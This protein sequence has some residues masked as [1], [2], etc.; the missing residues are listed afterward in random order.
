MAPSYAP[1]PPLAVTSLNT[2]EQNVFRIAKAL[3]GGHQGNGFMRSAANI[4][5]LKQQVS[6]FPILRHA[7]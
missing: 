1:L 2:M 4:T 5:K 7:N 6:V 3:L